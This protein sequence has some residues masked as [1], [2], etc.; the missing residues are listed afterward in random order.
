M[1]ESKKLKAILKFERKIWRIRLYFLN[2]LLLVWFNFKWLFGR[3]QKIKEWLR[4]HLQD[5][6]SFF[7]HL[8]NNFPYLILLEIYL[9]VNKFLFSLKHLLENHDQFYH[10]F[11]HSLSNS[12]FILWIILFKHLIKMKCYSNLSQ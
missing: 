10:R 7:F 11:L 2:F 12:L 4:N 8:P 9:F 1:T 5:W 3:A 6:Y